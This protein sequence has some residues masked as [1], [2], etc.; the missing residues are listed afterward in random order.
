M[1]LEEATG[2]LCARGTTIRGEGLGRDRMPRLPA[3][4]GELVP[5]DL[6]HSR[7]PHLA[8]REPPSLGD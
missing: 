4:C 5:T 2:G 6:A 1:S 8:T 7:P 3:V